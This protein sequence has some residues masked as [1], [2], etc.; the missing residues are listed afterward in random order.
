EQRDPGLRLV[1]ETVGLLERLLGALEIPPA[2]THLADLVRARPRLREPPERLELRPCL[3][4]LV[5]GLGVRAVEAHDLGPLHSADAREGGDRLAFAPPRGRLGPL[6]RPAVVGDAPTD[7]DREA[8]DVPRD[9]R[10]ELAA[11]GGQRRLV[12]ERE[13]LLELRV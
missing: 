1:A 12:H 8:V 2:Q 13:T 6:R 4:G 9:V 11:D 3:A 5:L 10:R 7:A